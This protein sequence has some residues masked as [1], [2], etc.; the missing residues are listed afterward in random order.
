MTSLQVK[1]QKDNLR[2]DQQKIDSLADQLKALRRELL[3]L[4][5]KS[6][7]KL[8]LQ[9]KQQQRNPAH[10]QQST[11][12]LVKLMKESNQ[13]CLELETDLTRLQQRID[14]LGSGPERKRLRRQRRDKKKQLEKAQENF[15]QL[16]TE[17][18]LRRDLESIA[19]NILT[20]DQKTA[21]KTETDES[22][23]V[24][25]AAFSINEKELKQLEK[26]VRRQEEKI[27]S[28]KK[29]IDD[30]A[31]RHQ[32]ELQALQEKR[33]RLE[34]KLSNLRPRFKNKLEE[35]LHPDFYRELRQQVF[36][37]RNTQWLDELSKDPFNQFLIRLLQVHQWMNGYYY[38]QLD[39]DLGRRTFDSIYELTKDLDRLKFRHVATM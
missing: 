38:G 10:H 28:I 11:E 34:E 15:K 3:L 24:H 5:D 25:K 23:A 16:R 14:Q 22:L 19:N 21:A 35:S 26:S 8:E 1:K 6:E 37:Q 31:S 17:V 4:G 32:H 27:Q 2:A 29:E 30:N 20:I 13:R 36:T 9:Q 33:Q 12:L 18:L 39:S 7:L